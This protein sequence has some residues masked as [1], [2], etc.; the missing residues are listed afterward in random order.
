MKR[1]ALVL[2][3]IA[4]LAISQAANATTFTFNDSTKVW[5][6]PWGSTVYENNTDVIGT[7]Q[8]TGGSVEVVAG[9]LIN[10]T[11]KANG[12]TSYPQFYSGDL[13][14]NIVRETNDTSWDY[15]VKSLEYGVLTSNAT[16]NVFDVRNLGITT[17]S[18]G[19]NASYEI[20]SWPTASNIRDNQPIG[21]NF[22]S[23]LPVS[24]TATFSGLTNAGVTYDFSGLDLEGAGSILLAWT[25]NCG[26]DVLYETVPVPEPGTMMLLGMG[27]LGLAIYGKRRMNKEA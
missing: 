13:F 7:P 26:N 16:V 9:D 5:P 1:I 19:A 18:A 6:S 23:E 11:I 8:I 25:V 2:G 20:S 24:S 21:I 10:V 15:I 27:M 4:S 22:R 14:I 17:A 12:L 3:I